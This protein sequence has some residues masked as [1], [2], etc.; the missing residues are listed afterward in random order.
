MF[1]YRDAVKWTRAVQHLTDLAEKCAERAGLPDSIRGL[2]VVELWAFGDILGTPRDLE[3]VSVAV[4]VDLP[5]VPWLSLPQGAEHWSNATRMTQNPISGFWR[6]VHAP[7]W[8]HFIDRPAPIWSAGTGVAVET[9]DAI[10]EGEANRF[11]LAEPSTQDVHKR[12]NDELAVSLRALREQTRTYD[13]RRWKPGK[14]TPVAD[15]LWRAADGYV[16]ILDA[17]AGQAQD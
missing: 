7:I 9:I 11:R 3:W 14:L 2:P 15:A 12:L 13:D 16:D 17:Q 10:R 4:A 8:N 5:E 1:T 6:S